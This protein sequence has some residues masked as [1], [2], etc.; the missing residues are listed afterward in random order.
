MNSRY[1]LPF[2]YRRLVGNDVRLLK[3]EPGEL[4]SPIICHLHQVPL[5]QDIKYI[6]LSYAWGDANATRP[7]TLNGRNFEVTLNLYAALDQLRSSV[8]DFTT[9]YVWI[10]AICINQGD[11]IEREKQIPRMADIFRISTKVLAWTGPLDD[12]GDREIETVFKAAVSMHQRLKYQAAMFSKGQCIEVPDADFKTTIEDIADGILRL[13]E[14]S[15]FRRLW[16][17]QEVCLPRRPPDL[18]TGR[19]VIDFPSLETLCGAP[20]IT[21]DKLFTRVTPFLMLSQYR[22]R[23][24]QWTASGVK[25]KPGHMFL[26]IIWMRS[27]R[28]STK[29]HDQIYGV[30]GLFNSL[31]HGDLPTLLQ[32]DYQKPLGQVFRDA[33]IY[34]IR[35]TG[36]LRLLGSRHEGVDGM[37]SWVHDFRKYP[38]H[39]RIWAPFRR[40]DSITLSTDEMMLNVKGVQLGV[41]DAIMPPAPISS[42]GFDRNHLQ[43]SLRN[44]VEALERWL[45]RASATVGEK[46]D[47]IRNSWSHCAFRSDDKELEAALESRYN[48]L[49]KQTGVNATALTEEK[50][51]SAFP[52][53]DRQNEIPARLPYPDHEAVQLEAYIARE[54][55]I[56]SE[57]SCS[58][59]LNTSARL[60]KGD[61]V[62]IF[63]GGAAPFVIRPRRTGYEIIGSCGLFGFNDNDLLLKEFW[64]RQ[65]LQDFV[66][67]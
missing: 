35:E 22:L 39:F 40:A 47:V 36:D 33:I 67:V 52:A 62:S 1:P 9:S 66:L 24:R 8:S 25:Y 18:C 53:S 32:P 64:D 23:I 46:E 15:W 51:T 20:I 16:V 37:P 44:R 61:V 38:Y 28:H 31:V 55:A 10:D 30:L 29:P 34:I 43:K 7:I 48:D 27:M 2:R 5:T 13:F 4:G 57:Q 12:S 6:A 63:L 49:R 42:G 60:Q 56:V 21:M 41:C 11:T 58:R 59:V 26:E 17:V 45:A 14:S 65:E 54:F 50:L 19:H 3:V